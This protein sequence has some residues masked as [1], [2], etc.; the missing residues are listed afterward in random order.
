MAVAVPGVVRVPVCQVH[1]NRPKPSAVSAPSPDDWL[2]RRW[3]GSP[4]V[5]RGLI[6]PVLDQ[7]ETIVAQINAA[8]K[9]LAGE[10]GQVLTDFQSI[11]ATSTEIVARRR[12]STELS[13]P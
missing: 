10:A 13:V 3:E 1:C 8:A 5:R 9:P 11:K 2:G 7:T 6:V 4:P 12:Q